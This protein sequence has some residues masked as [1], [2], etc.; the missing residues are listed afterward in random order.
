MKKD[1]Y[2]TFIYDGLGFPI[3]MINVPTKNI[4]GEIVL[5]INLGKFQR[6]ILHIL[7][8]KNQPLTALEI[9]FIRKYFEMTTTAFGGVFGVS[10]AAVL[11]WE[12]GQSRLPSTTE[13]CLRLFALDKLKGSNEEFGQ[14]YHKIAI[15]N[16]A[17]Q[18]KKKVNTPLEFDM[19]QKLSSA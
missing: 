17:E 2:N 14:L 4:F 10:H 16:L 8:Y 7:I 1:N 9:R 5:D 19:N 13:L 3:K 6:D 18:R 15:Q 11:K 12:S